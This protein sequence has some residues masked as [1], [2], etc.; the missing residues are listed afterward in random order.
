MAKS[1]HPASSPAV[2]AVGGTV[3]TL[4]SSGGFVSE[5][6]W[7]GSDG[8]P[9]GCLRIGASIPKRTAER[10]Y[11]AQKR[12]RLIGCRRY[13]SHLAYRH[14]QRRNTGLASV[15]GH[16]FFRSNC[17]RHDLYSA[18]TGLPKNS[19]AELININKNSNDK[20]KFRDITL[21]SSSKYSTLPG[22]D[23]VT[24]VGV[25]LGKLV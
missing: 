4:N 15:S 22:Y 24:G 1:I 6:G 25:P 13:S 23:F 5:Q 20:N 10:R 8:G 2:I 9:S 16:Q 21:G 3:L 17:R 19:Y 7:T 14:L 11:L 18:W 12:P